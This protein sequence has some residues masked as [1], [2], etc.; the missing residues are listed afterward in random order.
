MS[1]FN[2][3]ELANQLLSVLERVQFNSWRPALTGKRNSDG[4]VN[5]RIQDGLDDPNKVWVRFTDNDE[6][7]DVWNIP[8]ACVDVSGYNHA[9]WVGKNPQDEYQIVGVNNKQA[10]QTHGGAVSSQYSPS[11][12]GLVKG[13]SVAGRNLTM[14]QARSSSGLEVEIRPG[15]IGGQYWAGGTI[16][17][18][19]VQSGMSALRR[20]W[21]IVAMDVSSSPLAL[22][23]IEGSEVSSITTLTTSDLES[24]SVNAST[25]PLWGVNLLKEATTLNATQFEDMRQWIGSSNASGDTGLWDINVNQARTVAA[26][27]Q[28]TEGAFSI[29]SGGSVSV[30]GRLR[31]I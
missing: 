16:D 3:D 14:F 15:W 2:E 18:A 1:F 10:A 27:N 26:N 11:L 17:L 30:Y 29:V 7:I 8:P 12:N 13:L 19:S 4:S 20:K 28:R 24:I 21:V 25:I 9:V 5:N 22:T 31:I 23:A 6:E